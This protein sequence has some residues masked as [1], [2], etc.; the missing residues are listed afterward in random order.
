MAMVLELVGG[1]TDRCKCDETKSV[2]VIYIYIY[3]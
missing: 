1:K 2:C 3:I